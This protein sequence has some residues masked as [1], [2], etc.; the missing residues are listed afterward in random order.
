MKYRAKE[1]CEPLYRKNDIF[2]IVKRN[3]EDG[4]API[5]AM[6]LKDKKIYG[7]DEDELEEIR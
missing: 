6:R 2:V 4:I 3:S 1:G 7:F 5:E